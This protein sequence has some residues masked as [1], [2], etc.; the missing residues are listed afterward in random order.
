MPVKAAVSWQRVVDGL[1]VHPPVMLGTSVVGKA[2]SPT[3]HSALNPTSAVSA[4][5]LAITPRTLYFAGGAVLALLGG[6][7]SGRRG[8]ARH[9]PRKSIELAVGQARVQES[10]LAGGITASRCPAMISTGVWIV[11][12]R[13]RRIGRSW[14]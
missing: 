9:G 8:S 13:S 10:A 2:S 1:T 12:N 11:P 5:T 14:G 4:S 3:L 6:M 7:C